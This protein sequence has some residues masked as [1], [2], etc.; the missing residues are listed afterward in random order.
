MDPSHIVARTC[1]YCF[2]VVRGRPQYDAHVQHC[3]SNLPPADDEELKGW[4]AEHWE[5]HEKGMVDSTHLRVAAGA[6]GGAA[7][8]ALERQSSRMQAFKR[9]REAAAVGGRA[10]PMRQTPAAAAAFAG[11]ASPPR[12]KNVLKAAAGQEG[13]GGAAGGAAGAAGPDDRAARTA[14]IDAHND[15]QRANL[16]FMV[17]RDPDITEATFLPMPYDEVHRPAM[18]IF[19]K[20]G[21]GGQ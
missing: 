11:Q 21:G 6:A 13:A 1:P 12:K 4:T 5:L 17:N 15:Q 19:K 16:Q 14:F 20:Q 9:K 18:E 7:A 3:L 8:A 10:S 2:I